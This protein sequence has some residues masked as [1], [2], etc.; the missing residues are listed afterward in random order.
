MTDDIDALLKK[1]KFLDKD[2]FLLAPSDPIIVGS[3]NRLAQLR[4]KVDENEDE[5]ALTKNEKL[6][7]QELFDI[8]TYYNKQLKEYEEEHY[9]F[10]KKG[11]LKGKELYEFL[12]SKELYEDDE[13]DST[14]DEDDD[15]EEDEDDEDS[16][17]DEDED[18]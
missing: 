4:K 3:V 2:D 8:H 5:G 15:E 16:E 9:G 17:E 12:V 1:H 13:E 6:E 11:L 14:Y 10:T 18:E 7:F